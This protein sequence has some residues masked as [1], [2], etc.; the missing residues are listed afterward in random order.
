MKDKLHKRFHILNIALLLCAMGCLVY[1]DHRRGLW[2][3]G[4]TSGWFVLTALVNL[5]YARRRRISGLDLPILIT[6][7]LFFGL[8]ADVLLSHFF[9]LGIL[10]FALGHVLYV[11]AF[12]R[13][14]TP[15][16]GDLYFVLPGVALS[17]L[18]ATGTPY[19][20]ITD[21]LLQ[22]LLVG[23]AVI[24][25]CMLGKAAANLRQKRTPFRWLIFVGSA[26]FWF[27]DLMLAMNMFGT[28]GHLAGQLCCY[29]YWPAQNI[30]AYALFHY[31]AE[32]PEETSK[33]D[34]G[35]YV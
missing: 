4:V 30:L 33:Q 18:A 35:C 9:I 19:I 25:G 8:C 13:M 22:K 26:L 23:Y 21:P 17:L 10:S 6:L 12:C 27:S 11:V 3:K 24:I 5:H 20:Q 32:K 29:T 1:Y 2:L 31:T 14:E 7:G 28:G 15:C 16:L 34:V